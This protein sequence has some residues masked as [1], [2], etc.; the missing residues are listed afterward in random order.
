MSSNYYKTIGA[1]TFCLMLLSVSFLPLISIVGAD[2]DTLVILHPHSADVADDVIS[3]FQN[4]YEEEYGTEITVQQLTMDSGACYQ[5]VR[6]WAGEPEADLMWGGGEYYFMSLAKKELL[7]GYTVT[8]DSNIEDELGGWPLKDPE[9]QSRWYAAALSTFGI[10]WNEDYLEDNDLSPPDSW[11]DLTKPEYFGH[12]VMCDPAKSG[13]TTFITIMVI[14]HFIVEEGWENKDTGWQNAW[15]YWANVAGNVGLFTE[16]SSAVPDK[17]SM[18]EYGIGICIDYYAWEHF[19][20]GKNVGFNNGGGTSI[21][22]DPAGIL[23]GAPHLTEAQ[24]WMDYLLSK[25]GQEAVGRHRMPMRSDATPTEPV[26]SAW[27]NAKDVPVIP[28]YSRDMH[29]AMF[30]VVREMFSFWLVKNHKA[31]KDAND[32]INECEQLGLQSY[33]SFQTATENYKKIPDSSDT[34]D[35]ALEVDREIEAANWESWG[36]THFTEAKTS[37]DNAITEYEEELEKEEKASKNQ[38]YYLIAGVVVIVILGLVYFYVK[39]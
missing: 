15:E 29:N 25:R 17:V 6:T 11:E 9:G 39:R 12:I 3:D 30:S 27:L 22:A 7:E 34:L 32:K 19:K 14:E 13:S 5:Q 1:L 36:N 24:R 38:M 26:L 33:E 16:S 8:E 20:A 18:G 4:W 31:I 23:K 37:A 21:S 2:P 35:K 28:E 10:M